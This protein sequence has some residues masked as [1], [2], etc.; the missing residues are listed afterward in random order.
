MAKGL[1]ERS[2]DLTDYGVTY[3]EVGGINQ[4][5]K[6]HPLN[7]EIIKVVAALEADG[8]QYLSNMGKKLSEHPEDYEGFVVAQ[9]SNR[10]LRPTNQPSFGVFGV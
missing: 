2:L 9:E 8:F 5:K 10:G 4:E 3:R 1:T 6:T 7:D